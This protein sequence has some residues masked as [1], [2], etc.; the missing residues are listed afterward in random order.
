MKHQPLTPLA[1]TSLAALALALAAAPE[2]AQAQFNAV[3]TVNTGTVYDTAT[4]EPITQQSSDISIGS[5]FAQITWS[6]PVVITEGPVFLAPRPTLAGALPNDFDFLS[7]GN[8]VAFRNAVSEGGST[9]DY[10]VLNRILLDDPTS[11]AVFNGAVSSF[12]GQSTGGTVWFYSPGG[13][14]VGSAGSF[15]VGNLLLTTGA[16]SRGQNGAIQIVGAGQGS[17]VFN[18]G[19][20]SAT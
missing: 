8:S 15:D 20:L 12:I 3:P 9:G 7:A 14:L 4:F 10:T 17:G 19:S 13:I 6:T 11:R 5:P 1:A 18:D 16:V 2:R